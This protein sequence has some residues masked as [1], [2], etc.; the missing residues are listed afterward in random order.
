METSTAYAIHGIL[1]NQQIIVALEETQSFPPPEVCS[2]A[3]I[4]P[5]SLLQS[6]TGANLG[7]QGYKHKAPAVRYDTQTRAF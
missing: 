2:F 5:L 7:Q 4:L 6:G 3:V 1:C